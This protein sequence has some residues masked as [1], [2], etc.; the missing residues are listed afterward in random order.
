MTKCAILTLAGLS[1]SAALLVLVLLPRMNW[2][3]ARRPSGLETRLANQIRERWIEIHASDQKNPLAATPENLAAGRRVY[4]E[5]CAVCHGRDGSGENAFHADFYPPV[6]R[7]T[8]STQQMSDAEIYF[9]VTDGIAL[10]G[11]PAFGAGHRPEEVWKLI[12]WLRHLPDLTTT[13]RN[14]IEQQAS[15]QP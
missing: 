10:S 1:A 11:M 8:R 12:L 9:V 14:E 13:A 4:D 6:A 2:S 5:H 3:A 7:L 15:N